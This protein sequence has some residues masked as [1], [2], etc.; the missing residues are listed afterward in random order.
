MKKKLVIS[1][2]VFIVVPL[3]LVFCCNSI[4]KLATAKKTYNAVTEIPYN[5]VGLVLGT[6]NRLTNGQPNL[7]YSY[8]INATLE[9]YKAQKINYVLV[10]GDNGSIYYNEPNTIKKDLMKG[11]IPADKIFLDYAG[12]RTLDSMVRAH[13]IFGLDSVT[14]ISQQFHNERAIFLAEKKGM[15]AIGY[16]ANDITGKG[17]LKVQTREYLARV[18]VFIDLIF[19]T[20]PKFFGEK[21]TI[22]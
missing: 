13:A 17:G 19:K 18:K 16:N 10:S 11:G 4:I 21:I 2:L 5:R 12:F 7:Y 1:S 15:T 8:R 3:L 20:K 14:V 6:S 9:L 22:V